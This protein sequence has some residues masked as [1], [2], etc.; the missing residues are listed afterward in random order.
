[1][2]AHKL[3]FPKFDGSSDPLPWL[4]R[5]KRYFHVCRTPEYQ[6]VPFAAF[7]LLDDAQ[8]W[9]HR[10]ELNGGW[11]TWPQFVRMVN[12]C[13]GPSLT[14]NPIG[15]LTMLRRTS[16]VDECSKR[17]IA[18]SCRDTTLSETQQIQL[19]ITGSMIPCALM[20]PCNN[21]RPSMTWSSL[22]MRMSIAMPPVMPWSPRWLALH[23]ALRD[24]LR[25][26]R[27]LLLWQQHQRLPRH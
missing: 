15:E 2:T 7:C 9:F 25:R 4:N 17:F 12:A 20:S 18:L 24:G 22:P 21:L 10:M 23:H 13:F 3:E 27:C 16:G 5:Y 26:H 1:M 14:D 8:L 11:L 19:F 6:R